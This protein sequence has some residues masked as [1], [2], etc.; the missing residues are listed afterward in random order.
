MIKQ[1]RCDEQRLFYVAIFFSPLQ[2]P[3]RRTLQQLKNKAA[4]HAE[5]LPIKRSIELIF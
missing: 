4:L 2:P 5:R 1:S 3:L